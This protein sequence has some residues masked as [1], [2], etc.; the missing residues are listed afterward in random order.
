MKNSVFGFFQD[1]IVCSLIGLVM[2]TIFPI[3]LFAMSFDDDKSLQNVRVL[4]SG[5]NVSLEQAF[6]IIEQQTDFK[7]FYIKEDLPLHKIVMT[8]PAEESLYKILRELAKECGLTFNRV[9]HQ[10][11]VKKDSTVQPEAFKVQRIVRDGST[12]EALVF[13]NITFKV[14]KQGITTNSNGMCS[15]N[16][17]AGNDTLLCRFVGYKT[18]ELPISINANMQISINLFATD[19]FLQDVTVYA[20]PDEDEM[21]QKEVSALSLQSETIG[22]ITGIMPDVLRSVEMLPGVSNDNELSAK[23]NV[24]GGDANENLVLIDGTEVYDPYHIK[25]VSNA[26]IGI[27]NVDMIKKMDLITGGFSAR[28]GDRMSSVLD[29]EYRE[30]ITD[31]VK[32]QASL[33]MTDFDA[34][35]EGPIGPDGSFIIGARQSYTQYILK[36]L[37][38]APQIHPSFYDIQGV[39]AYHISTQDKLLLK[40][41]YAG[42]DFKYDPTTSSTNTLTNPYNTGTYSGWL[43]QSWHDSSEAH[44]HYYSSMF[45]IQNTDI[46]SSSALL[47]SEISYYDEIDLEHSQDLDLYGNIFHSVPITGPISA[48]YNSTY[49]HLY[50]NNLHIQ[51]L[52]FNSSFDM[53]IAHF[54][55]ITTGASYQRIFYF[56]NLI[57]QENFSYSTNDY[58]Y[59]IVTDSL[60][61]INALGSVFGS[62]DAQSF[63]AA[64]YLENIF[65]IGEKTILNVGGR[66]DYFDLNKDLTWSPRVNIAYKASTEIT[67][68]GAWGYF[69]QSPIY[70]QLCI[71]YSIR[72]QHAIAAGNS[73]YSWHGF[74]SHLSCRRAQYS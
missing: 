31:R 57:N 44:A 8:H 70:E 71:L 15:L 27:F 48:F 37:N 14:S 72:Y 66:F 68:R 11:V 64:G 3:G 30:G 45:A 58:K 42:D 25:E 20:N 10:I 32:G 24:H 60:W 33:S 53:Q 34:L 54:Y 4:I 46:I 26:S 73:L 23:F 7:F 5:E 56:Q 38:Q 74:Q 69:Y 49:N 22:K 51:T 41:I 16:L 59:P 36:M 62:M 6:Q 55:S 52:E 1:I 65:Q 43:S 17:P 63:K 47:K 29:I 67:V 35:L 9:D 50:D 21:S 12:H 28:C 19:V 40:F 39:L 61:N 13:A 18:V 2:Q